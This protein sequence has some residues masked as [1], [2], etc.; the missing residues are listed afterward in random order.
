MKQNNNFI[1]IG[2]DLGTTNSAI[3]VN[4]GLNVEIINNAEGNLYTPSVVGFNRSKNLVVGREAYDQLFKSASAESTLNYKAEVKRKMG[5]DEKITFARS[6]KA[7]S[8]EELSSEILKELKNDLLRRYP[9]ISTHSAVITIPMAFS[10]VQSEAT[11]R[12]GELAGFDHV[13]ILQEPI[14]AA[15]AYGLKNNQNENWLVYDL[16]GGTFDV[17]LISSHDGTISV[18]EHGGNNYLGGK[19]FDELIIQEVLKKKILQKYNFENLNLV[20]TDERYGVTYCHLKAMAEALKIKLSTL[21][22]VDVE[23][24]DI[25]MSDPDDK[26]PGRKDPD[27]TDDNGDIVDFTFKYTRSEYDK[28]ILSK[29]NET[30]ELTKKVIENSNIRSA[31]IHKIILV[32]APTLT[33]LI[34]HLLAKE[35]NV[36]VDSSMNPFTVVAEGAA[37]F[38]LSQKVPQSVIDKNREISKDEVQA[39][40]NVESMTNEKDILI[41][42]TFNL[43]SKGDYFVKISSDTGFYNSEKIKLNNNSFSAY[44]AL[45]L[46]KQNLFWVYLIDDKGTNLNIQP[47]SFTITQGMSLNGAPIPHEVGVIYS[48]QKADGTWTPKCFPYFDRKSTLPLSKSSSFKT[49]SEIDKGERVILPIEVYEGDYEDP[50]LNQVVTRIEIDGT[51]LPYSLKKGSAIDIKIEISESRQ[52]TVE[53]YIPDLDLELNARVDFYS[54]KVEFAELEGEVEE[55]ENE[56]QSLYENMDENQKT[57]IENEIDQIKSLMNNAPDNESKQKIQNQI[58]VLRNELQEIRNATSFDRVLKNYHEVVDKIETN[59]EDV[60][61]ESEK[62]EFFDT[63]SKIQQKAV[64]LIEMKQEALLIRVTEE[65]KKLKNAILAATPDYWIGFLMFIIQRKETLKNQSLAKS[66]INDAN[67]AMDENNID[68]LRQAV[69][70]L[71][72]LLPDN[73]D[74]D[75]IKG[76]MTGITK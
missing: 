58:K 71:A 41:T 16:G 29:V 12:A 35:L 17:A 64:Q 76:K 21:H 37:I 18:L 4:H 31:S 62:K 9:D 68:Q 66:L 23:L 73:D 7:Y 15:I 63:F 67:K 34:R 52:L 60:P 24:F 14:A 59:L 74:N 43:K 42:G 20:I 47:N 57:T 36:K 56:T 5:L 50:K 44:V 2:I 69:I 53:A 33:P 61:S 19:D 22:E 70:Q 38:A 25:K 13:V 39:T 65:L 8:P 1:R 51:N 32:G 72:G 10:T 27:L 49:I 54:K 30:I 48:E 45:E 28:L 3:A 40:L 26:V 6:N 46:Q 55:L 11:K 75:I